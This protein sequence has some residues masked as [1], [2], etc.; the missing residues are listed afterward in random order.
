METAIAIKLKD[1]N[2]EI[3]KLIRS[4][5]KPDVIFLL[6][7]KYKITDIKEKNSIEEL[8]LTIDGNDNSKDI[9]SDLQEISD[10]YKEADEETFRSICHKYGVNIEFHMSFRR[11]IIQCILQNSNAFITIREL[12]AV[13]RQRDFSVYD[14]KSLEDPISLT[15]NIKKGISESIQSLIEEQEPGRKYTVQSDQ[16]KDNI[17]ITAYFDERSRTYNQI[18]SKGGEIEKFTITPALKTKARYN[19]V[20]NRLYLKCGS[21][22]KVQ[23]YLLGSFGNAFF[24]DNN[25]FQNSKEVYKLE[26]VT[27]EDFSLEL[28]D[29]QLKDVESAKVIEET[30]TVEL[31]NQTIL[32]TIKGDD[33]EDALEQLSNEAAIDLKTQARKSITIQLVIKIDETKT[34][35]VN[36]KITDSHKIQYDPRY[37]EIVHNCLVKWGIEVGCD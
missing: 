12:S 5:K 24:S 36:I 8:A 34:K 16:V 7:E 4:V 3:L 15:E 11:V 2:K 26:K 20:E 32:L 22:Q 21:S 35:K 6:A 14:G 30:I 27:N 33:A 9:C 23:N 1:P 25:H 18:S 10:C 19:T 17:L 37:A 13:A 28:E 31:T 29:E